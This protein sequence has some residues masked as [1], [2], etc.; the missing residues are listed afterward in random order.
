MEADLVDWL[1]EVFKPVM[2]SMINEKNDYTTLLPN[3]GLTHNFLAGWKNKGPN[4]N[5]QMIN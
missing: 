4:S 2:F 1:A 5:D 3:G